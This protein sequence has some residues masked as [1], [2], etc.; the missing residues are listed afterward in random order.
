MDQI[1]AATKSN[2]KRKGN[3]AWNLTKEPKER[4]KHAFSK[5]ETHTRQ[6]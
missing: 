4:L 1:Q 5:E 3:E 2:F 6:K